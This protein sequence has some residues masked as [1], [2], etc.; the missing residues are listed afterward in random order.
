MS[1]RSLPDIEQQIAYLMEIDKLK[2]IERRTKDVDRSRFENSAEHSW[3]VALC[4]MVLSPYAGA[5][6]D[7]PRVV[8]MLLVHDIVEIDAGDTFAYDD[9][10]RQDQH[11][12][13]S[14]AADRIFGML[15]QQQG[16]ELL[17]LWQEFEAAE[18][19]DAKFANAIDRFIPLLHNYYTEGETWRKHSITKAQV[20]ERNAIVKSGAPQLWAYVQSI[21]DDSVSKGYLLP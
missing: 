1:E 7:L 6:I 3:H 5:E 8:Q 9:V 17:A 19:V 15:P 2:G 10:G 13:E 18:S 16:E 20:L 11:D 14:V 4:A 12:R 21:I